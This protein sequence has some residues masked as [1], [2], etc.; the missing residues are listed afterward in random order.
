MSTLNCYQVLKKGEARNKRKAN[1]GYF[2]SKR[3]YNPFTQKLV[4]EAQF[5]SS[6][7]ESDTKYDRT[8][9]N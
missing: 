9:K 4:L 5:G 3:L 1:I 2:W 6:D 8:K 7:D